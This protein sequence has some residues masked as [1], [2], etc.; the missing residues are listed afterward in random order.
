MWGLAFLLRTVSAQVSYCAM[1]SNVSGGPALSLHLC[2][3]SAFAVVGPG[4][5]LL[6]FVKLAKIHKEALLTFFTV[7][8][9]GNPFKSQ[10]Q[11]SQRTLKSTGV[12]WPVFICNTIGVA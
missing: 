1:V 2:V 7:R 8:G 9:A 5:G 4:F 3:H 6:K 11:R 10:T 12:Q